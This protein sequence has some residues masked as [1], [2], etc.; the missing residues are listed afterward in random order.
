MPRLSSAVRAPPILAIASI[1]TSG[2]RRSPSASARSFT[3]FRRARCGFFGNA[4]AKIS[5]TARRRRVATRMAWTRSMSFVS[6]TP[7]ACSKTSSARTRRAKRAASW[8]VPA[9]PSG[10]SRALAIGGRQ[11]ED[12]SLADA[13]VADLER[14]AE[15][16]AHRLEDQHARGQEPHA[17]GVELEALRKVGG[18]RAREQADR[19][20]ERLVRK[21]APGHP[22][23]RRGAASARDG[24]RD[25][26][27]SQTLEHAA[28]VGA[29]G[30][31]LVGRGR[32]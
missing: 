7:A 30:L 3:S 11:L 4:G 20:L 22:A 25:R 5:I 6:R 15:R 2:S 21:L 14:G 13:A 19:A 24:A 8:K 17:L 31:Q 29:R 26:G 16:V 18:R 32:V 27:R 9:S 10:I 28:R 23:Q 1:A 12:D